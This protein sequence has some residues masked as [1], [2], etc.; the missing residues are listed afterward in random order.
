M[1]AFIYNPNIYLG[2]ASYLTYI[3]K[4][5]FRQMIEEIMENTLTER[6]DMQ[7]LVY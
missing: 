2:K 7:P 6:V 3:N 4:L 1:T 5:G